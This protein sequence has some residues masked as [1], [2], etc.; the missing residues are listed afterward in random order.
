MITPKSSESYIRDDK[1]NLCVA[2]IEY[3]VLN[4]ALEYK[5]LPGG[6]RNRQVPQLNPPHRQELPMRRESCTIFKYGSLKYIELNKAVTFCLILA[7]LFAV[8]AK[9]S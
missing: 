6:C 2:Q 1:P 3:R 9:Q 8:V 5:I 7:I 4:A